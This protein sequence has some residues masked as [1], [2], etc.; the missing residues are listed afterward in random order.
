MW[1]DFLRHTPTASLQSCQIQKQLLKKA[2]RFII[3]LDQVFPQNV[4][5]MEGDTNRWRLAYL[6][7]VSKYMPFGFSHFGPRTRFI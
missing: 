4:I 5:I 3:A 7:F 6:E 1:K 2:L